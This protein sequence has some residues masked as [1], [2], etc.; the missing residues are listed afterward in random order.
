M[1]MHDLFIIQ[2]A[3][4]HLTMALRLLDRIGAATPAAHVDIA[5]QSLRTDPVLA[6]LLSR[7]ASEGG[8]DFT[9]LDGLADDIYGKL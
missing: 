4:A 1:E 2:S 5:L 6:E 3:I 7:P 9:Y 8:I